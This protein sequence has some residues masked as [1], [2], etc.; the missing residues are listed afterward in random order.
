MVFIDRGLG[1]KWLAVMFAVFCIF[2][3]FGMGN[4]SQANSAA[5]ALNSAFGTN[6]SQVGII[7]AAL[8]ALVIM[9]GI[10]IIGFVTEKFVPFMAAVYTAGIILI[11]YEL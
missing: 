9:G 8:T 6:N 3:S 2:A 4:M 1:V 11:F 5:S 10:K 7:L